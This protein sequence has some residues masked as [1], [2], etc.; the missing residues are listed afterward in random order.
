MN[1]FYEKILTLQL[2]GRLCLF[3]NSLLSFGLPQRITF[4]YT[5]YE[6]LN[7]RRFLFPSSLFLS[8]LSFFFPHSLMHKERM[9]HCEG[10]RKTLTLFVFA[11][12]YVVIIL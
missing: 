6:L 10:V 2:L 3:A 9:G 5:V 7:Q 8:L 11:E 4:F 1:S 12:T